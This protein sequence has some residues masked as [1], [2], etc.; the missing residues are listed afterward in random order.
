MS[1]KKDGVQTKIRRQTTD[2]LYLWCIAHRLELAALGAVKHDD[3]LSKFEDINS[4]IFLMYYLFPKQRQEF[5]VLDEI[6]KGFGGLK[7]VRWLAFRF[8][9][10]SMLAK[11]LCFHLQNVSNYG[12]T[13]NAAKAEGLVRKI[14]TQKFVAYLQLLEDLLSTLRKM[15]LVFQTD[16]LCVC[17]APR[18]IE[19]NIA[20]LEEL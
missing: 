13:A 7:R 6:T 20:S 10:T 3:Y 9:A 15:P 8:R 16:N 19:E 17:S 1:G 4:N 14:Q 5:K 12:D 2:C 18:Y 11:V